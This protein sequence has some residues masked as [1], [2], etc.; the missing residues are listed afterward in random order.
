M[1]FNPL[2]MIAGIVTTLVFAAFIVALLLRRK[3]AP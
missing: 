3:K 2:G 1:T